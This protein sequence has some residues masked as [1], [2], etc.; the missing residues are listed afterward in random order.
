MGNFSFPFE[1]IIKKI[2]TKLI[3]LF[4][5]SFTSISAVTR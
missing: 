4:I 1:M 3:A 5:P 2:S